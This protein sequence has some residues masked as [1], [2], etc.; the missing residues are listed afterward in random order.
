MAIASVGLVLALLAFV[1]E[2][3]RRQW[4]HTVEVS[5]MPEEAAAAEAEVRAK[6]EA[7]EAA[8]EGSPAAP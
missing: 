1:W 7:A 5:A 4:I 6:L 8:R 3:G 2:E